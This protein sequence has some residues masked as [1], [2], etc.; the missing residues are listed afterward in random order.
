MPT[1]SS[2]PLL[3]PLAGLLLLLGLALVLLRALDMFQMDADIISARLTQRRLR[4]PPQPWARRSRGARGGPRLL[5]FKV[6]HVAEPN[7]AFRFSV[8][9]E[10]GHS[11]KNYQYLLTYC[12]WH[13][14]EVRTSVGEA[15]KFKGV[16]RG[17]EMYD[18]GQEGRG[19]RVGT[20]MDGG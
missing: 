15:V 18:G 12:V 3:L 2:L 5:R 9:Q 11:R 16:R 8:R 14:A 13:Q 17:R 7:A 1:V 4:A 10:P 20:I 6:Q 19:K